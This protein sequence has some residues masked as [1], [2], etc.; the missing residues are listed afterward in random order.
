[1]E[2]MLGYIGGVPASY[3]I[4]APNIPQLNI[5]KVNHLL[6]SMEEHGCLLFKTLKDTHN[7][8]FESWAR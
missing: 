5:S 1:M 6:F 7:Y 2:S 4:E 8:P 3:L